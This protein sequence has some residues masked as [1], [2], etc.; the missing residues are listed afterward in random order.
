[1]TINKI[2]LPDGAWAVLRDPET[3]TERRRRPLVRLQ[4]RTI[5]KAAPAL[6][7]LDIQNMSAGEALKAIGP[8]LSDEDFDALEDID[9]LVIAVLVESWS[10]DFAVSAENSLDLPGPTRSALLKECHPLL[11]KLL[12][13]TSDEDVLDPESPTEPANV[14]DRP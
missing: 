10:F 11:G 7:E 8:L 4:R 2:S 12:G 5:A 14:S 3:V 1:M 9:D 13:E 6:A